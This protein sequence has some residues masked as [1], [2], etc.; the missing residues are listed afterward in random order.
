[1]VKRR[2]SGNFSL[3]TVPSYHGAEKQMAEE[4]AQFAVQLQ[5]GR[6]VVEP[7]QSPLQIINK[8][9]LQWR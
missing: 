3:R 7:K 8:K 6:P 5:T 1:L 9:S 4:L 2:S